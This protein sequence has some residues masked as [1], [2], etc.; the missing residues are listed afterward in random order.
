MTKIGLALGGG[1]RTGGAFHAGVL[2][3]LAQ[4]AGWDS[5]NAQIV[6]G[7]SAGAITAATLRAGMPPTDLMNRQLGRPLS[8]EGQVLINR[9]SR[10]ARRLPEP[11]E[12]KLA[13]AAPDLLRS[14]VRDLGSA[15]PGRVAAAALPEGRV[16]TAGIEASMG[17]LCGHTWPSAPLWITALRLSDGQRVVFGRD[18]DAGPRPPIGRAIAAS[19][20]IPG[21]FTPVAFDG[22]RYVDGG[23]TSVCNVDA[24]MGHD[25]DFVIVCAPMAIHTGPRLA[26]D[27][28][29]RRAVRRQVD[30]EAARL[31]AEGTKVF[32][33]APVAADIAAMGTNPMASGR[34]AQVARS[35]YASTAERI[36]ANAELR[37]VLAT[38]T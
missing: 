3:A 26:A 6:I 13:P 31:N 34:E 20:A 8:S 15:H 37:E 32:V 23:T 18:D 22:D 25:L 7:T 14:F 16:S 19:C 12:R 21:Y 17:E 5:S 24:L 11:G 1:G 4:T 28:P 35:V 10:D 9:I 36:N 2:G 30:R 38:A 33:F 29:I 27:T